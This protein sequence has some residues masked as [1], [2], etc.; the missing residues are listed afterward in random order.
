[1]AMT[2]KQTKGGGGGHEKAPPGNHLAVLVGIFDMGTQENEFG[3]KVKVQHRAYF[4]WEL[5][6]EKIAGTTKNHVIGTDLTFSLNEKAT[7]RK[8]IES[9]TGKTI[10]ED[11]ADF[12]ISSELGQPCMLSVVMNGEYPKIAGMAAVPAIFLKS[13]PK[14]TYPITLVELDQFKAGTPIPEWCP[15]LYGNE[16]SDHIKACQELG[17]VKP[18]PKKREDGI[19]SAPVGGNPDGS[20]AKTG[21]MIPF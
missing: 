7:L 8:W 12:D 16:L 9:R 2:L 19:Q 3:G 13:V 21:D 18:K 10:P 11:G 15:W 5:T 20:P 17:G 1:M 14:P 6:G 4:A